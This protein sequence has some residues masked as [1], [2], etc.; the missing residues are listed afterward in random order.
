MKLPSEFL[1]AFFAVR[2]D[3]HQRAHDEEH[4]LER[5][6]EYTDECHDRQE[7]EYQHHD[8]V[9]EGNEL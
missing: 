3:R 1:P 5:V 8:E 2:G 9:R 7:G 4:S 6:K